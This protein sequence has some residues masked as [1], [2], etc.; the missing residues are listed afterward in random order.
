MRCGHEVAI[1]I[2]LQAYLYTYSLLRRVTFKELPLGS[3]ALSIMMLPL[4][5][6]FLKLLL[7]KIFQCCHHIFFCLFCMFSI[8]WN[9]HPF[10]ADFIF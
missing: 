8:S 3:Y 10:I 7:W 5:E 9:L 6:I 1:K 4:F 2:L